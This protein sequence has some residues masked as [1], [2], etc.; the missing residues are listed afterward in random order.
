MEKLL[1]EK[2][3]SRGNE[4]LIETENA[5]KRELFKR[6]INQLKDHT[7]MGNI[8]GPD[9]IKAVI[10][11]TEN[12]EDEKTELIKKVSIVIPGGNI[13]VFPR[14]YNQADYMKAMEEND[15]VFCIGPAGTGKT[16]LAVAHALK[17]TLSRSK[18]KLLLTR[19]VVEAGE[20]LGYLP[21]DLAQKIS[22]Y[23][24][25][26]SDAMEE[27]LPAEVIARMEE[28]RII[29]I[30]PLAYMRGRSLR[31]SYIILDE[32]QNT[33]KEQMKMFLTR[34]GEGSKAVITGDITQ[35][36]L[37]KKDHSGLLHVVKILGNIRGIQFSYLSAHDVVRH[38]LVQEIIHAYEN[39]CD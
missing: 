33:T 12:G 35:I 36:D 4:L 1:N 18:R 38:P 26:L 7:E 29:E 20:S 25:P 28:T 37:P 31:N 32:A 6:I 24:R 13:K 15:V 11:S 23:L 22:P 21:G 5:E 2:I 30:A 3:Y 19:P 34:L 14:S 27:L 9:L 17:E 10:K 16:Y 39:R 8:P